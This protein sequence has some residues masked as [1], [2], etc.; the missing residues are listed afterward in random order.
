MKNMVRK[1]TLAVFCLFLLPA[2]AFADGVVL[3]P[4][5]NQV[6]V[7]NQS[8]V[9]GPCTVPSGGTASYS[10][11]ATAS[12][13]RFFAGSNVN[14]T[15]FTGQSNVFVITTQSFPFFTIALPAVGI[16]NLTGTVTILEPGASVDITAGSGS[17]TITRHFTD[18][19]TFSVVQFANVFHGLGPGIIEDRL[20]ITINGAAS[21][22]GSTFLRGT[23]PEPTTLAL[24]GTGLV[25]IAVKLRKRLKK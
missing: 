12:I 17:F 1:A 20:I 15:G 23:V 18:T 14:V 3:G 19:T 11:T 10:G 21:F 7:G 16:L 9:L 2:A 25:G 24:L 4:C 5:G 6:F 8:S 13:D 22:S